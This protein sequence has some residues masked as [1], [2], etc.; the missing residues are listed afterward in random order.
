MNIDYSQ[1]VVDHSKLPLNISCTQPG[2][3]TEAKWDEPRVLERLKQTGYMLVMFKPG[4]IP[5]DTSWNSGKV[6]TYTSTLNPRVE[7]VSKYGVAPK[8]IPLNIKFTFR[9]PKSENYYAVIFQLMDR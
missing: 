1:G 8:K 2:M 3:P 9:V 5:Y 6:N 4:R 7:I